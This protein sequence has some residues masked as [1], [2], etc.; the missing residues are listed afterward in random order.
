M[1]FSH[2]KKM[3]DVVSWFNIMYYDMPN[4]SVGGTKD[5]ATFE[6]VFQNIS[7]YIAKNKIL[8][9]FEPGSNPG[10]SGVWEG[11]EVDHQVIQYIK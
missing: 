9:G 11:F 7:K 10:A 1:Q 5:L 8:M 3:T 4:A 2:S 6:K